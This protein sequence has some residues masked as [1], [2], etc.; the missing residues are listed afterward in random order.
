VLG[1]HEKL[2]GLHDDY[3]I[4]SIIAVH[5]V[6]G[7]RAPERIRANRFAING[8]GLAPI[9]KTVENG[10]RIVA[11]RTEKTVAALRKAMAA[12]AGASR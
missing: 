4:S 2:E 6:N 12:A 3:Y 11:F 5:D 7:I 8:V 10:R 9:E 1:I